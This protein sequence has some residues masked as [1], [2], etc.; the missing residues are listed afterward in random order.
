MVFLRRVRVF[1]TRGVLN[2]GIRRPFADRGTLLAK[3]GADYGELQEA[4]TSL[5]KQNETMKNAIN[6]ACDTLGAAPA[7]YPPQR[8]ADL[9]V[10]Q[11]GR[12]R[13]SFHTGVKRTLAVVASHYLIDMDAVTEGYVVGDAHRSAPEEEIARLDDAAEGPGGIL[14]GRLL[15]ETLPSPS[16]DAPG[17]DAGNAPG[18]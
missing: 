5:V 1:W 11:Q 7:D 15:G 6:L 9:V 14:A 18:L 8:L 16:G 12:L 13:E 4:N 2:R 17:A 10:E 3:A